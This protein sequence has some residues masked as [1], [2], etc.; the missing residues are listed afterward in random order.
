MTE[1]FWT[2]EKGGK[3]RE[4]VNLGYGKRRRRKKKMMND[5]GRNHTIFLAA[6]RSLLRI[7]GP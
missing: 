3:G 4:G 1:T 6:F 2:K 5:D 7:R